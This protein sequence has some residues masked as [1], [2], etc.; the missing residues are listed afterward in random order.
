MTYDLCVVSVPYIPI[1]L[2]PA[3]PAVLKGHLQSQGYRVTTKEY[4]LE[5]NLAI[6]DAE[7]MSRL[8]NYWMEPTAVLTCQDQMVYNNVLEYL[9]RDLVDADCKWYGISVFTKDSRKFCRDFLPYVFKKKSPESK[10]LLGGHGVTENFFDTVKQFADVAIYG[11]GELAL[12][13]LLAGDLSYP[14]INSAGEQ[15]QDLDALGPPDYSDYHKLAQYDNFYDGTAVQITGSR[16]CVRSCSFCDVEHFWPKFKYRSGIKIAQDIIDMYNKTGVK[17]YFFTDSLINGNVKELMIMM[18]TLADYKQVTGADFTWGGQWIARKQQGLPKNYYKLIKASGAQNLT[19]GVETGSDAV[20]A[21]MKKGFTNLDLDLEIEQFS[22]QGI[23]CSF[24]II[25]GYPTETEKDFLDTLDMLRRYTK[26]VADG[27][28]VGLILGGGFQIYEHTPLAKEKNK[29]FKIE[30]NNATQW[31]SVVANVN[32]VESIRRRIMAQQVIESL[33]WPANNVFYELS[34]LLIS[35][36]SISP[37]HQDHN[38]WQNDM[39]NAVSKNYQL[40]IDPELMTLTI[41]LTGTK[42]NNWPEIDIEINSHIVAQSVIVENDQVIQVTVPSLKK[43]NMLSIRL[44]NK[45]SQDTICDTNGAIISD[46][47]VII[48]EIVFGDVR[49][50]SGDLYQQGFVICDSVKTKSTGLYH[51]DSVFKFY[52]ENPTI[53]FFLTS[54]KGFYSNYRKVN[55]HTIDQLIDFFR[56]LTDH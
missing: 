20:R 1:N 13:H 30:K 50:R 6:N 42:S 29:I 24:Y 28:L 22:Q 47:T 56:K 18:Q 41:S 32:Y 48:N 54:K 37:Q 25:I 8:V 21:H 31:T 10:I 55:Q 19:I 12:E 23:T 53:A 46:K 17:N 52:F 26:Y 49:V 39:F 5:T 43:R 44:K 7:L 16:G 36:K 27:T 4:N 51:A 33:K 9:S 40:P 38:E 15:I 11:E 45:T 35:L 2:P 3:A 34:S 14:G